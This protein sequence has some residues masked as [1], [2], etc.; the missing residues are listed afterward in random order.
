MALILTLLPTV[1]RIVNWMLDKSGATE[2]EKKEV[3]ALIIASKDDAATPIRVKDEFKELRDRL[4]ERMKN[5][6]A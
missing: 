1:L 3:T 5:K 2:A 6:K 4:A